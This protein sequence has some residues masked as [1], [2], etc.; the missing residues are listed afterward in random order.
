VVA[1]FN[2]KYNTVID[3]EIK[4]N[5]SSELTKLILKILHKNSR[6]DEEL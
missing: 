6:E 3:D 2:K 5:F 1:E 4:A